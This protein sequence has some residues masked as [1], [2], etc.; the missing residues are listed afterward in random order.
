MASINNIVDVT[1]YLMMETGQ[2]LHAFD[3][4]DLAEGRIVVRRAGQDTSFTTLDSKVHVLEPDMLMICDGRRPVAMAGVMGGENSEIRETTSRVLIESACFNPVSIRRTAKRSGIATDASHRFER[5]VDPGNTV[6][7]LKRAMALMAEVSGA[8]PAL[9]VIDEHPVPNP[10]RMIRVSPDFLNGRLGTRIPASGI[11]AV[12]ES[13]DFRVDEEAGDFL[14]HVPSFR[15]DVSRP[16]DI[17]EEVARLWGYNR[18]ATSFPAIPAERGRISPRIGLRREV[19]DILIGFGFTEAVNYSFT[20]PRACDSLCLGPDDPRRSVEGILNPISEDMAVLRTSLLPG[21]L[22]T[23]RR[24]NF[25][26]TETLRLFECGNVFRAT[27]PGSQPVETEMLAGIWTGARKPD[28]WHARRESCDFFDLK[29]VVE[30]LLGSLHIP[31]AGFSRADGR[32]HPYFKANAGAVMK[33]PAGLLGGI[34]QIH[35][36]VLKNFGLK[37]EEIDM[38]VLLALLPGSMMTAPLPKFPSITRD[39]TLVVDVGIEAGSVLSECMTFREREPLLE[40]V[41][42]FDVYQGSPLKEGTKSLS[43]RLVYRSW[44]KTLKEKMIKGIHDQ[45]SKTLVEKFGAALP[46]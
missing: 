31:P 16:E 28:S 35:Q 13:V 40:E 32:E 21:L 34:G 43:F 22:E 29:G 14:V 37:Q 33:T 9:G 2:P 8:V 26:Q 41:M 19:R 27:S 18:I 3:C 17:S 36:A 1:N 10:D 45:I 46:A 15:V 38:A 6:T 30:G 7:V 25:Q 44:E 39:I 23:M 4:D 5:G 24:N 42:L 11:R 20:S 12:L